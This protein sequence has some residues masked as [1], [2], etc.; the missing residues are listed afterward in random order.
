MK[1]FD[2]IGIENLVMDFALRI[3]RLPGTDGISQ[4][5]DYCW[6]SG[7]NVG[8]AIVALARLGAP[9]GMIAHTGSDSFGA[10]CRRDMQYNGVDDSHIRT[11]QGKTDFCIC[12]A[13]KE[14]QGRSLLGMG[15]SVE[16]LGPEDLDE[17]YIRQARA[18][19]LGV[20]FTQTSRAAAALA[21]KNGVLVSFDAAA[22]GPDVGELIDCTDIL[23]MSE[24]FYDALFDSGSCEENCRKLLSYG[25][26]VSIVTLGKRGCAGANAEERFTLPSFAD[27]GCEIVDTT[28]A[29]DVYHG[30]FLYA[31]LN[32]YKK[33][34]WNY[35]LK[36]CARFASAVSYIDCLSL[37]GRAGA[38]TLRMVDRLLQEGTVSLDG[39]AE[40]KAHY[41]DAAIL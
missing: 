16:P 41:R 14:T 35:S 12:L 32:R 26:S 1:R 27:C 7:G 33:P 40:R 11:T 23:I 2:V 20:P 18:I 37:G 39:L 5:L 38:P 6:Q 28:G 24:A 9:A 21:R 29:G 19:H 34:G 3:D 36:D 17:S 31:Y 8:S 10:Y 30:G 13:E 4:L 25:P 15:G 22:V